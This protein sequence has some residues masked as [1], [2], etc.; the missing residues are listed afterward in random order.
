MNPPFGTSQDENIDAEF[1]RVADRI[2]KESIF[3]IHK[4]ART[5]VLNE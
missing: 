1:L 4:I 5:K 3:F 2:A